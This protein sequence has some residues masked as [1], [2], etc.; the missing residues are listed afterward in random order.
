MIPF[1]HTHW[2]MTPVITS[3]AWY[4]CTPQS[5]RNDIHHQMHFMMI[6]IMTC[7]IWWYLSSHAL[8]DDITWYYLSS[9][10]FHDGTIS[11]HSLDND[12]GHHMRCMMITQCMKIPFITSLTGWYPLSPALHDDTH[13]RQPNMMIPFITCIA[14]WYSYHTHWIMT[15]VIICVAGYCL[16]L[17]AFRDDTYQLMHCIM[18]RTITG[19]TWWYLSAHAFYH[20]SHALHDDT[21]H[22]MH[23]MMILFHHPHWIMTPVITSVAW[24]NFTTKLPFITCMAWWYHFNTCIG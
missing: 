18:I 20:V 23:C 17:N 16:T 4:N 24:N 9:H 12:T 14:W 6:P 22:H 7:I 2:I 19:L 3:V 15:P 21:N 11:S 8:H 1:Q 13:Y 5:M 10:A